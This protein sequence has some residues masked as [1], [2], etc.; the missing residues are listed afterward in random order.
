M[1]Q[2]S[3]IALLLLLTA[4]ILLPGCYEDED[5]PVA[6][7]GG[8]FLLFSSVTDT[9]YGTPEDSVLFYINFSSIVAGEK[10]IRFEFGDGT[11]DIVNYQVMY[12]IG[13][14]HLYTERGT[15]TVVVEGL[16]NTNVVAK[17]SIV[18]VV[19]DYVRPSKATTIRVHITDIE[20]GIYNVRNRPGMP[21]SIALTAERDFDFVTQQW[22]PSGEPQV[23]PWMSFPWF[24]IPNTWYDRSIAPPSG[25]NIH[26]S[27]SLTGD[28]S[29]VTDLHLGFGEYLTTSDSLRRYEYSVDV[30]GIPLKNGTTPTAAYAVYE[31]TFPS[32]NV[33]V[34][35]YKVY[36]RLYREIAG[37][38]FLSE[39]IHTSPYSDVTVT[40]EFSR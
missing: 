10:Y 39:S 26:G 1:Y 11:M 37:N 27:V 25:R 3:R 14:R 4:A 17:D 16:S 36:R 29:A 12:M 32:G 40:V 7:P 5:N 8:D 20:T 2:L 24:Y 31:Q 13:H 19:Q 33:P 15:Y 35:V 22:N 38:Y 23:F 6:N 18:V 30:H 28:G 9:V 21:D 34:D